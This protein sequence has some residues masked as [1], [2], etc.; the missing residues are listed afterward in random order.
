MTKHETE[1]RALADDILE[2]D[3]AELEQAAGAAFDAY[4]TG[5]T[6]SQKG[7][8]HGVSVLAYA[9]VDGPSL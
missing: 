1:S 6:T 3:D 9:R 8:C 2:L 4:T 7:L 5:P